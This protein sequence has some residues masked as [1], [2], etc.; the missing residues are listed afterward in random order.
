MALLGALG[1]RRLGL[2]AFPLRQWVLISGLT[3]VLQ[4]LLWL[5]P[6]LGWDERIRWDPHYVYLPMLVAAFLL[7]V[8]IYFAPQ[9]RVLLLMFWFVALL[10]M[11][12]LA[13]GFG[14][15]LLSAAMALGYLTALI[16]TSA[17]GAPVSLAFEATV[18][19]VFL[20]ICAYAG[21]LFERLRRNREETKTLRHQLANLA[22]TDALT[23]LPNRRLLE[24]ALR[25]ELSK[26]VRHGGCC[27]VAM[28]DVDYFKN[29]NDVL[30]HLAGD[31]LLRELA[32]VIRKYLRVGDGVGRYGGEE[33]A[34]I[35]TNTS[36]KEAAEVLNRLRARIEGYWFPGR[37]AQPTCRITISAGIATCPQDGSEYEGLLQKA[38]EALYSAKRQGRNRV[39]MA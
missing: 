21:V 26:V 12:G 23:G 31:E 14:V 1:L 16:V 18:A 33:F 27:S 13:G 20:L 15:A 38:D 25:S 4:G 35:M 5:L 11:A 8:Y 37:E 30:G 32:K 28:I 3:L 7:S 39:S 36:K 22:M 24:D 17:R 9:L 29:Y 10:F 6:H 19:G 34:L 2:I